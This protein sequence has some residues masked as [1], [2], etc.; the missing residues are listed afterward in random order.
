MKTIIPRGQSISFRKKKRL[1]GLFRF[2]KLNKNDGLAPHITTTA[3]LSLPTASYQSICQPPLWHSIMVFTLDSTGTQ[4]SSHSSN[5]ETHPSSPAAHPRPCPESP[6]RL[7]G[8]CSLCR[9]GTKA[10]LVCQPSL[11]LSR[12]SVASVKLLSPGSPATSPGPA[13]SSSHKEGRDPP[14]PSSGTR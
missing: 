1:S 3:R 2:L 14:P 6:P 12:L 4:T 10:T 11:P 13:T 8:Q 5:S 7:R 9:V